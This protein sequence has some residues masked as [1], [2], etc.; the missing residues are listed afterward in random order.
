MLTRAEGQCGVRRD[1]GPRPHQDRACSHRHGGVDHPGRHR[2][3]H[4]DNGVRSL[5]CGDLATYP[6]TLDIYWFYL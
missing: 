1:G 6:G 5:N 2:A 3:L 4:P